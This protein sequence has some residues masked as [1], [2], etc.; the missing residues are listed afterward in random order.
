MVDEFSQLGSGSLPTH[1]IPT[2]AVAL[3]VPALSADEL[4]G[5]L[6]LSHPPVFTRI[7]EDRV[8][9]DLRTVTSGEIREI[10]E[11]LGGIVLGDDVE[12]GA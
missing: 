5:R 1:D 11:V 12:Q 8:L 7:R 6:R 2:K 10:V 9:F 3:S 4:A